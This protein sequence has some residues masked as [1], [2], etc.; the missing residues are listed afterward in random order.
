MDVE[1]RLPAGRGAMQVEPRLVAEDPAAHRRDAVRAHLPREGSEIGRRERRVAVALE[2]EVADPPVAVLR[3]FAEDVRLD[4]KRGAERRQ[5]RVRDRELL[6]RRWPQGQRG[7]VRVHDLAGVEI[8][9]H[10]ARCGEV[11]EGEVQRLREAGG[12]GARR[13][14]RTGCGDGGDDPDGGEET[15]EHAPFHCLGPYPSR[16]GRWAVPLV[17]MGR[18]AHSERGGRPR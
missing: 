3:P 14:A 2:H 16:Q 6:V 5:R 11:H 1:R 18:A 13:G 15:G 8:D 4:A 10:R 9:D 17:K 7:V 12:E